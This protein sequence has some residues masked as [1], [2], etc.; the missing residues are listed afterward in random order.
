MRNACLKIFPVFSD[1]HFIM[2]QTFHQRLQQGRAGAAVGVV[3]VITGVAGGPVVQH[4]FQTALI[5]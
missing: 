3:E 4:G 5:H 2:P 1:R